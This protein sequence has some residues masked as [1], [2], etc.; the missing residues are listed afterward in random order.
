MPKV[1]LPH[2]T[3]LFAD[4]AGFTALTE[5]HGDE[6][7]ADL[8][9]DFCARV[10]DALPADGGEVVKTIGD[11]LMVRLDSSTVAVTLGLAIAHELM[12]DHGQPTVRVGMHTGPASARGGD[13]FGTTVNVAA[14][15]AGAAAGG[16]VLLSDAV[17]SSAGVLRG[18][19]FVSRGTQR[20]RNVPKPIVL[21]SAE[22]AGDG[23]RAGR[24]LDP[25][26]HMVMV[27]GREAR[28]LEHEG[29]VY[30]FCSE[31]CA[32]RF[33]AA[34]QDYASAE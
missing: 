14:R 23:L 26:C 21:F 29:T 2:S 8:A 9:L 28:S 7:A 16:E 1:A 25:V 32:E 4:I 12:A 30:L 15:I 19:S 20:L 11:A 22:R 27:P 13:Y 18:V 31:L 34:P 24:A 33:A 17:R 5:A 6:D 10:R 3:F